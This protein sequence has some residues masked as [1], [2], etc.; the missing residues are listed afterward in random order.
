MTSLKA[1]G[2]QLN[3]VIAVLDDPIS[4]LD[5]RAMTHVVSMTRRVFEEC[6][7]LFILTHNLEFMREM[8][9]WF[10]KNKF[11]KKISF[12]F[13]ETGLID[14]ERISKI[15]EMPRLI[16]EYESEYH[17]LY[18]LV[19]LL[20]ESPASAERF[21]YLMPNAIRK[22]LDIFLAFKSPGGMGLSEKVDKILRE[23][24]ALDAGRVKA[25]E[26]LAQ[27]ESHSESVGDMITFSAYTLEQVSDAAG[28]LMELI[29]TLDPEHRKAM[30]KLCKP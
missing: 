21:A 7:Q 18:S 13:I 27:L 3:D 30:D 22:V 17:Y 19:K 5:A 1:E 4:S 6:A 10:G 25:M 16:R 15:V 14:G 20:S 2:R 29:Q 23:N 9:K 24:D 8:K 28:C 26:G 12:L 11:D